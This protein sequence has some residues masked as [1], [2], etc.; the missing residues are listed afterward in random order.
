MRDKHSDIIRVGKIS[1]IDY[2]KCT[3]QVVFE[4]RDDIV[5]GDLPIRVP[6]T[7]KDR[8]YYMPDIDE[9]VRCVFDPSAPTKGY[10]D[11][12]YYADTR[13]PPIKNKDATYIN[14]KDETLLMY[15]REQHK[16]TIIILEAGEVSI[17]VFA[18]SDIVIETNGNIDVTAAKDINVTSAQNINIK[19]DGKINIESGAEMNL[20]AGGDM[21]LK[22]PNIHL[23]P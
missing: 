3:A 6:K 15:D 19:A 14:F 11:G 10:I 1:S 5:S 21:T 18:E 17:D 9:R 13:L 22:A 12:S 23:N 2:E 16:L 20:T 7:L 8:Y 4:D